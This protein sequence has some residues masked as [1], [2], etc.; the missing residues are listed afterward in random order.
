LESPQTFKLVKE[1]ESTS[2]FE[3]ATFV[4]YGIILEKD[5]PPVKIERYDI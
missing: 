1:T 3:E 2:E 5:L 4:V